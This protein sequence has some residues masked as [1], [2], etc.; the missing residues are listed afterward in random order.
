MIGKRTISEIESRAGILL[1]MNPSPVV[2]FRLRR[3]VL[4]VFADN[5]RRRFESSLIEQSKQVQYLLDE[6]REDGGW[7]VFH[8]RSRKSRQKIA[9]TEV[10]VERAINLGL[11]QDHPSL[12]RVK[13][14][15]LSI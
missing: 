12:M 5:G 7:G 8:S 6:Q 11:P 4:H 14:Y 15:I 1:E 10:G 13:E 3:D 2:Q 9:S